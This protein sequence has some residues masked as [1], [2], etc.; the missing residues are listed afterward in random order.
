MTRNIEHRRPGDRLRRVEIARLLRRRPGEIDGGLALIL[1]DSD[2]DLDD[3]ALIGLDGEMGI[4][5]S[6]DDAAHAF[7]GV[8]LHVPH[9]SVHHRQCEIADHLAQLAH[10]HFVGGDLGLDVVDVLQWIACRIAA[11]GQ[12]RIELLLAE[13][14]AIDQLEIVDINAF[15][16]DG[17]CIGRHRAR[18]N[19]A[20]I[21][22][23]TA[24]GDPEQNLL[25]VEYRRADGN[26]GQVGAAVVGRVDDIGV[27]RPHATLVLAND[28]LDR[29]IH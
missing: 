26:V 24:R 7:R 3:I 18:R 22:M 5:Q 27:A 29:A 28:G 2:P 8:V 9:I 23:V 6:V 13:A 12:E 17:R 4:V 16:L 1:V 25:A 11:A 20:D 19:A 15:L 10:A 21:G 14:A